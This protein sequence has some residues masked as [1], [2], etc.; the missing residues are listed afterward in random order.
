MPIKTGGG[1]SSAL[2]IRKLK[3]LLWNSHDPVT[4]K[5]GNRLYDR[6]LKVVETCSASDIFEAFKD[7]V[8]FC[9]FVVGFSEA[10]D[11]LIEKFSWEQI[12]YVMIKHRKLILGPKFQGA[13]TDK[14]AA[15]LWMVQSTFVREC[16]LMIFSRFR[17]VTRKL[18]CPLMRFTL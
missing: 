18:S 1:G 12:F 9:E 6:C 3:D 16:Y 4:R 15:A 5:E 2:R 8:K 13:V 7:D 14:S 10:F 11:G 17:T